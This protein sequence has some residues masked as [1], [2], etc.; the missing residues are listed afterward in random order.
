VTVT[1]CLYLLTVGAGLGQER[2]ESFGEL[3]LYC[4]RVA[5][6]VGLMTLP[7]LGKHAFTR[8]RVLWTQVEKAKLRCYIARTVI[9]LLS[10][11]SLYLTHDI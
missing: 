3:Y 1:W 4:Y 2:Y 6:T 7:I 8:V 11:A 9:L 10:Y 5:G